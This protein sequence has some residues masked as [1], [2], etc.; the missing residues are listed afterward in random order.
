MGEGKQPET[1]SGI[2]TERQ[3]MSH[4]LIQG[5]SEQRLM[6]GPMRMLFFEIIF[7]FNLRIAVS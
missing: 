2:Y 7:R 5:L 6:S 1:C 3:D 4:G